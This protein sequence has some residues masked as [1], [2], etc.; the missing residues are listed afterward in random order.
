[1]KRSLRNIIVITVLCFVIP[2]VYADNNGS[3]ATDFYNFNT[4][5]DHVSDM[6]RYG[7]F[8]TSLFT[9]RLRQ[10]IPIFS[11]EDPD[12]KMNIALHYN[13]EGFKPRKH[14]GYVGYNWFL[15][16]GGCITRE[17]KG[18]PDEI[19]GHIAVNNGFDYNHGIEG[20]YHFA[21][22][23]P[24]ID[25]NDVFSLPQATNIP[26]CVFDGM[27]PNTNFHNVGNN[28]DYEVDYMPDVFNFDFM[29]Y[30]G[31]FMINNAGEVQII[32]GDFIDVDLS[33][34]LTEWEPE[35]LPASPFYSSDPSQNPNNPGVLPYPKEDSKI[36]VKTIDGYTYI[37]G[38]D[39]SK[40]EYTIDAYNRN[41]ILG[42]HTQGGYNTNPAIVSTWHLAEII[43]PNK[44]TVKYFYKPAE[45]G[46]RPGVPGGSDHLWEFNV[47]FNKFAQ[48]NRCLEPL[49]IQER[50]LPMNIISV[51]DIPTEIWCKLAFYKSFYGDSSYFMCS[52]TKSCILDSIHISGE[53]PLKLLFYNSQETHKMY[54]Y[55]GYYNNCRN[56]YQLDSIRIISANRTIRTANLSYIY[57]SY[58]N[59]NAS[60]NWRFLH[61]A[62]ISGVGAYLMDYNNNYF[63]DVYNERPIYYVYRGET[64]LVDDYGYYVGN[65][66]IGL[67]QQI[68]FPTG[69]YQLYSYGAYQFSK[70][71]KYSMEG[72]STVVMT[73]SD[74]SGN[75]KGVR[76]NQVKTFDNSN[77][78]VETKSFTYTDGI[79]FDNIRVYNLQYDSLELYSEY[80]WPVRYH[81]DY[82]FLNTHIGYGKVIEFVNNNQGTYKNI[83][84]FDTGVDTYTSLNDSNLCGKYFCDDNKFGV[85]SGHMFY[86]SKLRKWGKLISV[87]NY[88]SDNHLL[89]S[90]NYEY[91]DIL[92]PSSFCIDTI[93]TYSHYNSGYV[94][95][96]R[97]Y[98]QTN[99]PIGRVNL[100]EISKKLYLYPDVLSKEIVKDYSQG[101][102]LV[103]T[104]SYFYD[105]KLRVTKETFD[106]SRGIQHFTKYTYPDNLTFN[107]GF[108]PYS[109]YSGL[110]FLKQ[111]H[112]I[113]IP[114]EIVSGYIQDSIEYVTNGSV[115]LYAT[116]KIA[117]PS[118]SN[119]PSQAH[120]ILPN[121]NLFDSTF[122]FPDS[123]I[124]PSFVFTYY[125]YLHK[126]MSLSLA[127]P[128]CNYQPMGTSGSTVTYDAHYKLET[129]FKFDG[130]DRLISIKPFGGVE[131]RYTWNGIYPSSKTTGNQTWTYTHIPHVG[132]SS[133][134]DPRGVTTY[135]DYDSFGR[136]VKEY[137]IVNDQ[138]QI[139]NVYQY[140]IKTE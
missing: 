39:I 130:K 36:T 122:I 72:G 14:S 9:G 30:H 91:N 68:T 74:E 25:K 80:G 90:T 119:S 71:R 113:S 2:H 101:D 35:L 104:K 55:E 32:S 1:M 6:F 17:V 137:Q 54:D 124:H 93:V 63:P 77:H 102:S 47:F 96:Y 33:G 88:D 81:A 114:V 48:Y 87:E 44:R 94:S 49:Y 140:H 18:Y 86:G 70:K 11:L 29:G 23:H 61:S 109:Q 16:A 67:L 110:Y 45:E 59:S 106:D 65:N 84:K 98:Y 79:Y 99:I 13:S 38:G 22:N 31:A 82:G 50:I 41:S 66:T 120:I 40:L 126:T 133:I 4:V 73:T 131:T 51:D 5:S 108:L 42:P 105:R 58:T 60:C 95:V 85:I 46:F 12:F 15:E 138:E 57:G 21:M 89:K 53:Q 139:L 128:I 103:I 43:A 134:T 27:N 24:D 10:S 64:D 115:N 123:L 117:L 62:Q 135:Y 97:P 112:Q 83:Y 20:M 116:G 26:L 8:K 52:M 28:C 75:R 132:I 129:E 3:P 19:R 100:S 78:L 121:I 34:I 111:R 7:E 37:F 69:G 125:P 107:V 136:L 118:E 56:N 92:S 76:I 127:T